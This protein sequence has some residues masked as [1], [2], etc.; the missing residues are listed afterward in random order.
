M[1]FL[2]GVISFL[3][4]IVSIAQ[5]TLRS[6]TPLSKVFGPWNVHVAASRGMVARFRRLRAL[7][8]G[9]WTP[10]VSWFRKAANSAR[11]LNAQKPTARKVIPQNR[12]S[13]PHACLSACAASSPAP[14]FPSYARPQPPA[15]PTLQWYGH[16]QNQQRRFGWLAKSA[17]IRSAGVGEGR[18]CLRV[19]I[20]SCFW[21]LRPPPPPRFT[22]TSRRI[23]SSHHDLG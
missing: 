23:T 22:L 4:I 5:T 2:L 19:S 8:P 6:I 12:T 18:T 14:P 11:K 20:R 10:L 16:L 9:S 13:S 3:G 7:L 15:S 1:E 17:G 21:G